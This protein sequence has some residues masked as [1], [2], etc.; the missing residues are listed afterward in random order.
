MVGELTPEEIE[1]SVEATYRR[2]GLELDEPAHPVDIAEALLGEGCVRGVHAGALPGAGSL[3]RFQGRSWIFF[4][5][6]LPV[7]RLPFVV[8]HEIGHFVLGAEAPEWACDAFAGALLAPRRA[9]MRATQELGADWSALSRR[10]GCTESWAALRWGEVIGEPLALVAPVTLRVR[11]EP[12]GWPEEPTKLRALAAADRPGLRKARL[13]DDP[14]R[15]V[16]RTG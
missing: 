12:Y 7:V 1:G 3:A 6:S 11:G 14:R 13:R 9:F 10:F 15:V 4:R 8:A 16:L 2:A 5:S